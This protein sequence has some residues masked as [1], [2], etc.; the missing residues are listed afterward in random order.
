MEQ[1]VRKLEV[2]IISAQDLK[3]VSH[4][5]K[6][7]TFAVAWVHPSKKFATPVDSKNHMNPTWN[8][9]IRL[10]VKEV[11]LQQQQQNVKLT[12]DIYNKSPG[13]SDDF[14]GSCSVPLSQLKSS[15]GAGADHA[16]IMSLR[17]YR[18]SGRIQGILSLSLKLGDVMQPRPMHPG[19]SISGP[20]SLPRPQAS[21]PGPQVSMPRPASVPGPSA[22]LPLQ[23][24]AAVMSSQYQQ[25]Y[26]STQPPQYSNPQPVASAGPYANVRPSRPS[27]RTGS[28]YSL[29]TSLE[30]LAVGTVTAA[31]GASAGHPSASNRLGA[32][33]YGGYQGFAAGTSGGYHGFGRGPLHGFGGGAGQDQGFAG[34]GGYQG[35]GG[36]AQQGFGG[37]TGQDQGFVGVAAGSGAGAGFGDDYGSAGFDVDV[38]GG[39]GGGFGVDVG[40]GFVDYGGGGGGGGGVYGCACGGG[41]GCG[42]G[43]GF[44][45]GCGSGFGGGCGGC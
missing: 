10:I 37:G 3:D 13:G 39:G 24:N 20:P 1:L 29:V 15:E 12:V 28:L 26:P 18:R 34:T 22:A 33:G 9:M 43:S 32:G 30:R 42:G 4:Y 17:V 16:Q 14:V 5:G 6:M 21:L 41:G 27:A 8:T 40:D 38:G 7:T 31:L 23:P 25:W 35:F 44:G 11:V 36:G 2:T 45:G 19:Q